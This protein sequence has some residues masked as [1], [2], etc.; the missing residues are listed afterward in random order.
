[1]HENCEVV[2]CESGSRATGTQAF[3]SAV[4]L[5]STEHELREI[6]ASVAALRETARA[7]LKPPEWFPW[8]M[9]I[10]IGREPGNEVAR[11]HRGLTLGVLQLVSAR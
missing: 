6:A 9:T 2:A 3:H 1:M 4:Q 10:A 11:D 8:Q 5:S 7:I